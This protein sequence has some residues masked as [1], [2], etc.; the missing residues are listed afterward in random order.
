M[1]A[2]SHLDLEITSDRELQVGAL[3]VLCSHGRGR[4]QVARVVMEPRNHA[5]DGKII[6]VVYPMAISSPSQ[7]CTCEAYMS[8]DRF[9]VTPFRGLPMH[10]GPECWLE[11]ATLFDRMAF[12]FNSV[13]AA[14][15]I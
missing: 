5:K 13:R 8:L 10:W 11:R 4:Y 7:M 12:F 3:I 14:I 6:R 15:H 9:L 1:A 2:E